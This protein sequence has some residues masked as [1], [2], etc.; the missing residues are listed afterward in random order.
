MRYILVSTL[1]LISIEVYGSIYEAK[2]APIYP[3]INDKYQVLLDLVKTT[4]QECLKNCFQINEFEK[5]NK[6]TKLEK[7]IQFD[8][9]IEKKNCQIQQFLVENEYDKT[10]NVFTCS[11]ILSEVEE[12]NFIKNFEN[13]CTNKFIFKING[14]IKKFE[15]ETSRIK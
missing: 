2:I 8:L 7:V 12:L 1:I 9:F 15:D 6:S 13:K 5:I 3:K 14:L 11:H 10:S 4:R